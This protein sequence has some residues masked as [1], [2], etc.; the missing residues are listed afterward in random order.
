MCR[1][2]PPAGTRL[3]PPPILPTGGPDC[4]AKAE[5][6]PDPCL[7]Q[8][9]ARRHIIRCLGTLQLPADFPLPGLD[10]EGQWL[11]TRRPEPSA[12]MVLEL[13]EV[14]WCVGDG[15]FTAG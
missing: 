9:N 2:L 15:W 6:G 8:Q 13:C 1:G 14:G 11:A 3:A 7:Q 12:A 4:H 10:K 5:P